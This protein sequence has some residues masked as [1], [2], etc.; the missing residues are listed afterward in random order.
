MKKLIIY[1]GLVLIIASACFFLY[2]KV[3]HS[4]ESYLLAKESALRSVESK[5][6]GYDFY[7]TNASYRNDR[8]Y[9]TV[10]IRDYKYSLVEFHCYV[11][12]TINENGYYFVQIWSSQNENLLK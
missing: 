4:M 5:Y 3:E 8:Y 2:N 1:I 9:V 12:P 6:P 7:V 11:T 10:K